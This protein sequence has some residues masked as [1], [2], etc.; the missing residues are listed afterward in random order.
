MTYNLTLLI[1]LG[2]VLF[3]WMTGSAYFCAY[4]VKDTSRSRMGSAQV[5]ALLSLIPP[6]NLLYI[7]F[8]VYR[9]STNK[10][11]TREID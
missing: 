10:N 7:A 9:R 1:Q 2:A 8:L 5:G 3:V 6:L 4:L 11:V